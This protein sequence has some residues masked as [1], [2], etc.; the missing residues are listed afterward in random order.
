MMID[1]FSAQ[2]K[3]SLSAPILKPYVLMRAN[4][5]MQSSS[6]RGEEVDE[7]SYK[8][9]VPIFAIYHTFPMPGTVHGDMMSPS[10]RLTHGP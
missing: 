2:A 8:E 10:K 3:F 5:V 9:L 4:Q 1:V 6:V 7:R